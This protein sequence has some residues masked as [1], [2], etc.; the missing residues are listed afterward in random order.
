MSAD[1][2]KRVLIIANELSPYIEFTD[3]AHIL[4]KL[5]IKTFDSGLEIRVIMPRFGVINERRHR[6][7]EVVRLS[8]INVIID[9]DD[10]PLQIKVASLPNARLQ[11]YF[12]DNEDY[13]KRKAVFRDDQ[14]NFFD[15]NAERMIFF[16]KSALE[17]V[18]KFG[19]PPHVIHCHGWM[20]SL[21]P[22]YL[23]TAYKKE[24]VFGYSKVIYTA[25]SSQFDEK[26][27]V[28]FS[29]KAM[30]SADIKDKDFELFKD[31]TNDALTI[32]AGKYADVVVYGS[33]QVNDA[34]IQE[35]KPS[36]YKKV[37]KYEE[38][39]KEDVTSLVDLY[40]SLTES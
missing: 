18:K 36:R 21:I 3:F 31:G 32:G 2:K 33:E 8:G 4:N 25:Q 20:T 15:D 19:W 5:A 22:L 17:T 7:H 29:K 35:L 14:D 26:L 40:K 10:Y 23:K 30:I 12:M 6:L 38:E 28:N 9:K 39:W 1:T 16:C 11:V 27:H 34:I 24:P 13:F 37:V